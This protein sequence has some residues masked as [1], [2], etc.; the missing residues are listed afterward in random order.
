MLTSFLGSACLSFKDLSLADSTLKF[1]NCSWAEIC[2]STS[3][4]SIAFFN[5]NLAAA[6]LV[7]TLLSNSLA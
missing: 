5:A 1:A 6:K 2:A 3:W 7:V 4:D